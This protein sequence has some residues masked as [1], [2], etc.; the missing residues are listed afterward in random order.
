[1]P[2][3][4]EFAGVVAEVGAGVS[5]FAP[6]DEIMATPT[7]PCGSCFY[8]GRGQ[9]NLCSTAIDKMVLGAFGDMLVLPSHIVARNVFHKPVDLPFEEGALLEPLS[10]VVHAHAISV[11]EPRETVMIL[12]AGPFGILHMMVL[13]AAGVRQVVVAGRGEQRLKWAAAMGADR[14]I[15]V[16]RE[17]AAAAASRLNGGFGPDL[18]IEC[19]GQ[20]D[21]WADALARTRRGG[22]VVFF[23]GCPPGTALNLDTRRMHYDGLTLLAPFHYRPRDVHRSYELLAARRLGAARLISDHRNLN[24]LSEV[25]AMMDRGAVLKCA[26]IP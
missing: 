17:D 14:V 18:V 19:T 22:R 2:L 20:I 16:R 15:D 26:V 4:H 9:E 25:F 1:M 10:C 12:G 23:G 3:G 11:P 13:R 21:G 5:S 7:A 24:D 6:G 8:C